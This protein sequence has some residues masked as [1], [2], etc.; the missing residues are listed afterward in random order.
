MFQLI[1]YK[2]E[3]FTEIQYFLLRSWA[4]LYNIVQYKKTLYTVPDSKVHGANMGPTW[5]P[6]PQVG[7]M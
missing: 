6:S 2:L 3:K 1:I 5:V 4:L 7:P